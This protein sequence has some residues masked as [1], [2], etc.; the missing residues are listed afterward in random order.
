MQ[1]TVESIIRDDD[2]PVKERMSLKSEVMGGFVVRFNQPLPSRADRGRMHVRVTCPVCGEVAI[3]NHSSSFSDSTN[4]RI[5]SGSC[6]SCGRCELSLDGTPADGETQVM[7]FSL[8]LAGGAAGSSLQ[9]ER[10]HLEMALPK[11]S[12]WMKK[13]CAI[14]PRIEVRTTRRGM[15]PCENWTAVNGRL[16]SLSWRP[17]IPM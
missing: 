16:F 10:V 13:P 3:E 8:N 5:G 17:R 4:S 6:M 14:S 12:S 2:R 11:L 1:L 7:V 15:T 9:K